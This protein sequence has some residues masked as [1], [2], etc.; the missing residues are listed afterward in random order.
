MYKESKP[1]E[2]DSYREK[3]EEIPTNML[4]FIDESGIDDNETVSKAWGQKG[5]RVVRKIKGHRKNRLSIVSAL[6][7]KKIK[8]PMVFDG[9]FNTEIMKIYVKKILLPI[10]KPNQV[11]VMDN[12][13]FHKS[14]EIE[15]AITSV[16]CKLIYLPTYSPDLNPIEHCWAVIKSKIRKLLDQ[17]WNLMKA[18]CKV[19]NKMSA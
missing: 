3:I 11:V 4:V 19:L 5:K 17:G 6:N 14:K 1:E 10:L 2:R 7:N 8:A 16:G 15:K 13:S 9:Y 12:A 18:T